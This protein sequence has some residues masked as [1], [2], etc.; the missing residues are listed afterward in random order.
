ML[1]GFTGF[2]FYELG[3][4]EPVQLVCKYL[5]YHCQ[6]EH[7]VQDIATDLTK[8]KRS[9]IYIFKIIFKRC[10]QVKVTA[11]LRYLRNH[12]KDEVIGKR[13]TKWCIERNLRLLVVIN[14]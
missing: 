13:K 12:L 4:V 8:R 7:R 6:E 3:P 2:H 9:I 5:M 14:Y 11:G 10:F 1:L